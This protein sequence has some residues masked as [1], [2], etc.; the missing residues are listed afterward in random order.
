MT[1]D[2]KDGGF[3]EKEKVK[4]FATRKGEELHFAVVE[5]DGKIR[6]DIRF[7]VK[8]KENKGMFAARRGISVLPKH[9]SEFQEGVTQLAEKLAG[10]KDA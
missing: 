3:K 6:G 1:Q 10:H 8:N 9:F 7:F 4:V 2:K 5:V